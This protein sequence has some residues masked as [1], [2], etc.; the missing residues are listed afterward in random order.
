MPKQRIITA[1]NEVLNEQFGFEIYIV[2]KEGEQLIKRF[3]LDE[4]SPNATDG[5]KR[6][7][8]E[9]IKEA[10]QS[11]FLTDD[12]KYANGDD[13]ANEQA[14]FYVIRQDDAYQPFSYLSV[15]ENQVENF[16][17]SDKNN[18]DAIL[19]KFSFQR[20]GELKQLWAYQKILPASIPNRRTKYFQLI[21]K[22]Q[23][24]Q[25]VFT[26][27]KEQMFI[28]TRKIDLLILGDEIITAD[29]KLMERH[30]GLET[31]LRA[32][33]HTCGIVNYDSWISRK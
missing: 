8:R 2:M 15:T 17:L 19:F 21:R 20:N 33:G 9:S 30:F 25:D 13:L 26:E 1:I 16:K 3:V 24:R 12:S 6:K 28:I 32:C 29:I 11:K 7:I 18:A 14:F 4:G 23:D 10:I 22:S 5:F 27:M 31:F